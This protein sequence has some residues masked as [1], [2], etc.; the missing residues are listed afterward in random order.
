MRMS[1]PVSRVAAPPRA[2][3][4]TGSPMTVKSRRPPPPIVPTTTRPEFTPTP[5][6]RRPLRPSRTSWAIS[7]AAAEELGVLGGGGDGAGGV[8]GGALGSAEH[9]QQPVADELVRM[10]AVTQDHG[11]DGVIEVVEARDDLV[12]GGALGERREPAYVDEQ[13][14]DV[15]LLALEVRALRQHALGQRR[16]DE[17]AERLAE[18]LAL[19]EP[20]HHRVERGRE[21]PRLVGGHDG[22]AHGEVAGAEP[23]R[24]VAEV[25]DRRRHR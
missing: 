6:C 21:L 1:S 7:W 3:V 16:I 4:L 19:A 10:A 18:P 15:D 24:R 17:G 25:D 23:A 20:G 8:I 22:H 9:G 2:A 13:D 12:G 11:D 5:T 14:R